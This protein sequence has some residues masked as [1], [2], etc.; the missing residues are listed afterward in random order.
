MSK[1]S[2]DESGS[3]G[4]V[5]SSA[6]LSPCSVYRYELRRVWN[7][8]DPMVC[9]VMLNPSTADAEQDDPT[10]RRCMGFARSWGY[11]GIV[12]VNLFA[13]RATDS[14]FVVDHPDP[15]GP[16]NDQHL[17][18]VAAEVPELVCAWGAHR[19]VEQRSGHVLGLLAAQGVISSCIGV[20]K[21]GSPRHP[22]YVR[23]AAVPVPFAGRNA[24]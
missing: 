10:I 4:I 3:R 20:T 9:W 6:I 23:S 2:P 19:M 1:P 8:N 16:D 5:R 21:D 17:S 24:A 13:V 11:G 12:V 15:V 22:L 7:P 18:R 14:Q